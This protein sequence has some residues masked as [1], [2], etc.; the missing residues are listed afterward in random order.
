MDTFHMRM[1]YLDCLKEHLEKRI[2][3]DVFNTQYTS[4]VFEAFSYDLFNDKQFADLF[5]KNAFCF[6]YNN[7]LWVI[8]RIFLFMEAIGIKTFSLR[9]MK[10]LMSVKSGI[11]NAKRKFCR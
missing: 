5:R 2:L 3:D 1:Y 8:R 6:L 4:V 11:A 7:S 9:T 10:G